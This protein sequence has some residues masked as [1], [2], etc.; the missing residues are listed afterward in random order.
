MAATSTRLDGTMNTRLARR[1]SLYPTVCGWL[2]IVS[3]LG[4][5]GSLAP[6]VE[7][8][9]PPAAP[10]LKDLNG[11][12]PFVPPGDR[13]AWERRAAEVRQ[14]LIVS[15]GLDP[16]PRFPKTPPVVHSL[17][18]MDGYSVEKVIL[19]SFPGLYI[20]GNLYRPL[21][22]NGKAPAILC[23][24]GHWANA[25][26]YD[27]DPK[28]M[29]RLLANGEERFANGARN[30][31]QARCVQLA[32]MGCIVFHWDMLG[33]SDSQQIS[34]QRAHG[35]RDKTDEENT[36]DQ[37]W[38]LYSPIAE[39]HS[40]SVM[41]IQ[42]A[43]ALRAV[44]F[45]LGLPEVDP[46]R[47]GITGASGGGTQTF[48][49]AAIDPRIKLAFPAV[50]VS[51]GMQGGCTCEN[52]CGLRI[53]TGN[54]EIAALIAPRPLGLTAADD[55]TKTMPQDGFPELQRLFSLYGATDKVA[56]FPSLHFGHN[57]NHVSRVAMYGWVN[58][59][60][61]MGSS[62]PVLETDFEYLGK[63]ALSV[64]DDKH[65]MPSGGLA[66]ER[67]LL[68]WWQEDA[69]SQLL[70]GTDVEA[71]RQ[72]LQAG[73][74]SLLLPAQRRATSATIEEGEKLGV[75]VVDGERS[76]LTKWNQ[77]KQPA[78]A[79]MVTNA[80][81]DP[82]VI[83][84]RFAME[85]N[86]KGWNGSQEQAK[87][88]FAWFQETSAAAS[89]Q[90]LVANPRRSAAYT[91]GF[92]PSKSVRVAA[93]LS[94]SIA[95][96]HEQR[97]EKLEVWA[98]DKP[99]VAIAATLLAPTKVERLVVVD[100][101]WRLSQAKDI[102]DVDFVPGSLRYLDWPG[103]VACLQD[104]EVV[105]LRTENGRKAKDWGVLQKAGLLDHVKW[106]DP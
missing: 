61:A 19:E 80:E 100:D 91:F 39:G 58:R 87:R 99:F 88:R 43:H 75:Q 79:I 86:P 36:T 105:V 38:V 96:L 17:R 48:I 68:R 77:D 13:E 56:L 11:H 67:S 74:H 52:A 23:P 62:E 47:I 65:P 3:S 28:E 42:T 27:A 76:W 97:G 9:T 60:F 24:H 5:L 59:H 81:T 51:T 90:P 89:L 15:L 55:W 50:M 32:R 73:W 20:T 54:V 12:F 7:G 44:D 8:Q 45:V 31:I 82:G 18:K 10:V 40:Q 35:F 26:F 85:A 2:M 30:H 4:I 29:A 37:G 95:W 6:N 22:L 33:N 83:A 25:R 94:R 84:K 53:D 92:N 66:L 78:N 69:Q 104:T 49:A 98:S 103:L 57:Y 14:Q 34:M 70:E 102:D 16:M 1:Y 64:W 106:I 63:E 71:I 41:G 21:T 93:N 101:G 46:N 72:R